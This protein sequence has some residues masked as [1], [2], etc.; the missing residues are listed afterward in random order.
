MLN[1][2]YQTRKKQKKEF[3]NFRILERIQLPSDDNV[4]ISVTSPKWPSKA[5]SFSLGCG[6]GCGSSF[7]LWCGPGSGCGSGS[8]TLVLMNETNL[9][10]SVFVGQPVISELQGSGCALKAEIIRTSKKLLS[11][12]FFKIFFWEVPVW[13]YGTRVWDTRSWPRAGDRHP[14][15]RW[16]QP[17]QM[18]LGTKRR[19]SEDLKKDV[20]QND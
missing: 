19:R 20:H 3:T 9:E 12:C 5:S 11:K 2:V 14:K 7:P 6:S 10:G 1:I 8:T 15:R 16:T 17:G 4:L 18:P 13:F